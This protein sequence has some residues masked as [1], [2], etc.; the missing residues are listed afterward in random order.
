MPAMQAQLGF[1]FSSA[2]KLDQRSVSV[3]EIIAA[4]LT[5]SRLVVDVFAVY[6]DLRFGGNSPLA[7]ALHRDIVGKPMR[8][9][10]LLLSLVLLTACSGEP[11]AELAR[12]TP[13]Q[14][15]REHGRFVTVNGMRIFA[16]TMGQ[17]RNVVLIHGHPASTYTWR[18]VIEPLAGHYRVDAIDL[19]GYGF[20]D[21]PDDAKYGPTWQA[22]NVI[23]YLDEEHIA[24]A[25]LVGNSFGG[26]VASD[27]AIE[28]PDR[29][30]ALVL[31]DAA[32][33]PH[34][35]RTPLSMR[36]L[37]WPVIGPIL[38]LLPARSLV[39]RGLQ[40]AVYDPKQITEAD[41]EAYYA[42]LRTDGGTNA[43]IDRIGKRV[44]RTR[45]RLVKTI[46][47]PTLII[48]G[49]SDRL[50]PPRIAQEY[51]ELIH[52]SELAVFQK[53]GHLPQEERPQETVAAMVRFIDAHP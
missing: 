17:G 5:P 11:P 47:A 36:M 4:A 15:A 18:K 32:G 50:V 31:I 14:L 1:N 22:Q 43:L 34:R 53:T 28:S 24:R 48:T 44:S 3:V 8:Q 26:Y 16:I 29:V 6:E 19:P 20:S 7:T 40:R 38:R 27:A 42:P 39:R 12:T 49:D 51:H 2:R 45:P 13:F 10:V 25:V 52:G 35:G 41:V 21:K 33:L 23:G 37:A 9:M 46:R 30:S